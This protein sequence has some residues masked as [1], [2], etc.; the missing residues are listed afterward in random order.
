MP[1]CVKSA[2][3]KVTASVTLQAAH[4]VRHRT[5][6]PALLI[7]AHGII[8]RGGILLFCG[9]YS[10]AGTSRNPDLHLTHEEQPALLESA[11]FVQVEQLLDMAAWL[12][13]GP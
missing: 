9:H 8:D 13:T 1:H 12:C 5:R 10:E 4:E 6:Q 11:G 2:R 3:L 7:R